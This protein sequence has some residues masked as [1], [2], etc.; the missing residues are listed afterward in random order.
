M[1]LSKSVFKIKS[2]TELN[3]FPKL[4]INAPTIANF[5]VYYAFYSFEAS[6]RQPFVA[7]E[8]CYGPHKTNLF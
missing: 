7:Y 3:L 2:K 4:K 8:S 1:Q 5:V 6:D